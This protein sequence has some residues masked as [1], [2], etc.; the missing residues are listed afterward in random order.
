M[1]SSSSQ[2][3]QADMRWLGGFIARHR[4]AAIG[5]LVAGGVAG[6]TS[7]IEPYLIG[8]IIDS[9][10]EQVALDQLLQYALALIGLAIITVIAFYGQRTW[11]GTVAYSVNYDIRETLFDNLLTLEQRFYQTYPTGDL[12]SRMYS[13]VDMIWRLLTIGFTRFGSAFMTV[14]V[15]FVLLGTINIPLTL[16]VFVVLVVSTA[17]QMKVGM[18]LAPVFE[19]VQEQAG[20][21]SALVQDSVSGIQTVKTFGSEAGVARQFHKENIEY[22]RRWLFFKRR[23]E[24]VGMLPN[25]ISELTAAIVVM[26]GGVLTLQGALTL[27]NF[28]QFLVY[29]SLISNVLLQLGTIYQRYQQTRGALTRLTPLLQEAQIRS[30]DD[31]EPLKQFR[32]EIQFEHVSVQ[33]EGTWLLRDIQLHIPAGEVVAF[34]GPTGCGKTLLVSLL[35]RVLDPDEGVVR[36]DGHDVRHVDLDD[37]RHGITYVPQS[38]FL[39]SQPV[40]AN[41]R[42]GQRNIMDEELEKAIFISRLSNDLPQLPQGLETLVGEKGVM[43]SGGQK[44]R[45]AIA[46]AIVRNPSIL[47]LDDALSSVDTQ[48][49]ADILADLR[50]V[51]QTRTSLIIAHRIATV[52][53]A[54]RIVVMDEGR[55]VESGTHAALIALDGLYARMV[56]RELRSED[57]DDDETQ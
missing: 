57:A 3:P 23:N 6:I 5:S 18:L 10:R 33:A 25:M 49:A 51:L 43:L 36:I 27:G 1:E 48:T 45:V 55:I 19:D 31:A 37:L 24:P 17:I 11:S 4:L 26:F 42:M 52:K 32:G 14:V 28:V 12:I 15:A 16:V 50:D 20:V 29:L 21:V 7:A 44:Q 35:A 8:T 38:T 46:R 40:H 22:K 54:D 53:D 30:D 2:S 47:V 39:F 13:D 41:V 56:E 9:I 34:V